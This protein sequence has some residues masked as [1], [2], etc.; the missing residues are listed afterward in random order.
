M[1]DLE[2]QMLSQCVIYY[3]KFRKV[4]QQTEKEALIAIIAYNFSVQYCEGLEPKSTKTIL[5][6]AQTGMPFFPPPPTDP[7]F[8]SNFNTLGICT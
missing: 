2:W 8:W 3:E 5:Y 4:M 6:R 7:L 1:N